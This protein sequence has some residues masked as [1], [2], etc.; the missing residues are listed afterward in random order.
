MRTPRP[1]D[2]IRITGIM[3]DDPAPLPIGATGTVTGTGPGQIYVDWDN[4]RSLILLNTDPYRIIPTTQ[5]DDNAHRATVPAHALRG[6]QRLDT[7]KY[8][9]TVSASV[10][11]LVDI[12]FS[13]GTAWCSV[14]EDHP[15]TLWHGGPSRR[16]YPF[17]ALPA[18]EHLRHCPKQQH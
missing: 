7:G 6:G 10:G 17:A 18:D 5:A 9:H 16:A 13:D 11:G 2:R 8:V 3:A 4:G 12:T 15:I 1:G 14:P